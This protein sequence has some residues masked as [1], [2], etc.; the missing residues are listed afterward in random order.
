[1]I[2]MKNIL[3]EK[4]EFDEK[5]IRKA[6]KMKP[7]EARIFLSTMINDKKL[8]SAFEGVKSIETYLGYVM[9]KNDMVNRLDMS[10]KMGLD[11]KYSNYQEIIGNLDL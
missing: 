6:M 7:I 1:M 9:K 8:K 4:K 2:K 10:L 5:F 3:L 11:K